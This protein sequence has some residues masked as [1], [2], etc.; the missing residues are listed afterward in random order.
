VSAQ[1]PRRKLLKAGWVVPMDP[2]RTVIRNGAVWVED[3][4]VVR[5]GTDGDPRPSTETHEFPRHVL[6]PGLVNTHTHVAGAIFRGLLE[7]RPDHFYGF[8]LP[9]ER[10]LDADSVHV[11]SM[12]GIAETLLAGCTT[13]NDM[14]HFPEATAR[15]AAQLGTRAQIAQKVYDVDLPRIADGARE[16]SPGRGMAKLEANVRLYE[17]WH[18]RAG[19]R[20]GIRFGLHASDT[21]SPQLQRA[22]VAEAERRGAGMHTH[23]AQT[24]G[25][26]DFIR[27][28]YHKSPVA[29]LE[30]NGA[31][32]PNTL[33][34][35]LLF[36]DD[37]DLDKLRAT[38]TCAAVCPA[39]V[40][41]VAA[42]LGPLPQTRHAGIRVGWGTDWVSMDP[43]DAMRFGIV[44]ARLLTGDAVFLS[45]WEAL[46]RFTGGAAEALN[47]EDRVGSVEPGKKADMILIDV[48]QPH[49]AP[50]REPV[51]TIVYN[52]SG[53]D[54][55]HVMID[56]EF[57]VKDRRLCRAD[58][59]QLVADG[60]EAADRLWR[61]AQARTPR[62][63]RAARVPQD[64]PH[65]ADLPHR[66]AQH[67]G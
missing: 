22:V 20:I 4:R 44:S 14:F 6:L 24:A 51:P 49:L 53:R 58:V 15:A 65:P 31:L 3:D 63:T 17:T 55:T 7:D 40:T 36:A 50:M 21:C 30:D 35:H 9:M 29:L 67:P 59:G 11:L 61:R 33:A 57:V 60:Q 16:Y 47:W 26:R 18:L 39:C 13:I 23:V 43:F 52:A 38:R 62:P 5:V 46:W 12:L 64:H 1:V 41:K 10:H 19:E 37:A 28:R 27:E 45:A 48:D 8:A 66:P 54:V 32:G 34:V 25:E 2:G 42:A 56:G